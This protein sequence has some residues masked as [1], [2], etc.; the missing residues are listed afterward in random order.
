[1]HRARKAIRGKK[2]NNGKEQGALSE[3]GLSGSH[4]KRS[5]LGERMV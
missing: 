1:M 3:R 5:D 4:W 2:N